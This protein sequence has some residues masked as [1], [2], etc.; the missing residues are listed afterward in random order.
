MMAKWLSLVFQPC[1]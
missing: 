1:G